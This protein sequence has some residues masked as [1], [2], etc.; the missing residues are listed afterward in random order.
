MNKSFH[1]I[2]AILG[3]PVL[4]ILLSVSCKKEK[5]PILPSTVTD[6]DGNVYN[7]VMIG[8]QGWMKENLKVTHY[9]D[10]TEIPLITDNTEWASLTTG[11]YS[12]YGNSASMASTYGLLYNGF[13]VQTGKLCPAGWRVPDNDDWEELRV[14][15]GGQAYAGSKMKQEGTSLWTSPNTGATNSS[16]F[17]GLPGG[18]RGPTG[19]FYQEGDVA[20]WWSLS[21]E[22]DREFYWIVTYSNEGLSSSP[23]VPETNGM[24]IRCIWDNQP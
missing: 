20:I 2:V 14:F 19:L 15:L 10:G 23:A 6:A 21:T 5:A 7:T 18:F 4:L 9:N 24:S 11:S 22:N 8:S 17:T 12:S 16:G 1:R 13:S 3:I